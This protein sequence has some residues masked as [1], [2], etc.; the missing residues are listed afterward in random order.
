MLI[1]SPIYIAV[2]LLEIV[3]SNYRG[4]KVYTLRETLE[5][6]YLSLLNGGLDLLIRGGYL[7][8]LERV[9]SLKIFSF[10]NNILYWVALFILLDLAFYWLHRL[11]HFSRIFWAVHVTHHSCEKMNFTVGFRAS[12]FQ[13]LYRFLFF[14]PLAFIGFKPLD[15]LLLYSLTVFWSIFVHTEFIGKL[16]FLERILVTPSHHRVHHASNALYLDKNMGLVLIIWDRLFGT[17]QEEKKASEYQPIRYGLTSPL[18]NP[19]P[20]RLIF[21]EWQSILADMKRKDISFSDKIKYLFHPPGWSHDN[22]RLKSS[23]LRRRE[24]GE[25]NSKPKKR[26]AEC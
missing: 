3:I 22:S 23:E 2:I 5:N 20:F 25:R 17:F 13:P 24:S 4:Q 16:G 8:L 14:I 19:N 21:H 26:N 1:A 7:L 6:F 18:Q 15:I 9:Y 12:V 11:E 10:E